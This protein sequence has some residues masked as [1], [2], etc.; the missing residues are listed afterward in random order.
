M[1]KKLIIQIFLGEEEKLVDYPQFVINKNRWESYCN[2]IGFEYLFF[3]KYNIQKYLGEYEKFYYGLEFTWQRIDFIRYLILNQ[4]GGLYVDLDIYPNPDMNICELLDQRYI[5]NFWTE[6]KTNIREVNNAMMGVEPGDF[7][8]LIKYCI[9]ET[10]R[11]RNIHIYKCW[12]IRYMK[13]STGVC[14]FK[15]WIKKKVWSFTPNL[16]DYVTDEMN[17]S[18]TKNFH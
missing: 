7:D 4:E 5:M 11:C 17:S 10:E 2:I 18:W 9:S 14:M 3:D 8:D 12:K 1:V 13:H 16:H 6:P 15:R